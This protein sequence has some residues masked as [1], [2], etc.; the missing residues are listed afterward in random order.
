MLLKHPAPGSPM[1]PMLQSRNETQLIG[2][3]GTRVN[4]GRTRWKFTGSQM[5]PDGYEVK[6]RSIQIDRDGQ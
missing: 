1:R 2:T 3:K 6:A 5:F 4:A